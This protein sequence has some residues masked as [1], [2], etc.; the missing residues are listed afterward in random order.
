MPGLL[1]DIGAGANGA[2]W[3]IAEGRVP[4]RWNGSYWERKQGGLSGIAVGGDGTPW[5]VASTGEVFTGVP[6][7]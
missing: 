3:G 1:T 2:V 5:A 4:F 6:G 7:L